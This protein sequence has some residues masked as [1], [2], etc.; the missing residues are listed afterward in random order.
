MFWS[1]GSTCV[2]HLC[3]HLGLQRIREK[4]AYRRNINQRTKLQFYSRSF[5][6]AK[7]EKEERGAGVEGPQS[8]MGTESDSFSQSA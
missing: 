7:L 3:Q 5:F 8:L 6:T 1:V 4:H 2:K